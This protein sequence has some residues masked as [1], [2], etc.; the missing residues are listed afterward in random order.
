[1][2]TRIFSRSAKGTGFGI[3]V[4]DFEWFPEVKPFMGRAAPLHPAAQIEI[5]PTLVGKTFVTLSEYIIL[6]FLREIREGRMKPDEVELR[7]DGKRME[8]DED[9]DFRGWPG[10]FYR[11]RANLLFGD[12]E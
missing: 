4:V 3:D 12:R 6:W 11:E 10:G 9:G 5:A 7:C 1:M 8:I 2:T